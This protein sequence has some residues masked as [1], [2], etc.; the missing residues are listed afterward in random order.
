[1]MG[2][3]RGVDVGEGK[4]TVVGATVTGLAGVAI[5]GTAV[6]PVVGSTAGIEVADA[7][8]EGSGDLE[9]ATETRIR[10]SRKPYSGRNFTASVQ[11]DAEIV[12]VY[13]PT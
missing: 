9:Q 10:K 6:G 11:R 12:G 13:A 3:R 2:V 1:M 5:G 4:G 8:G 7:T